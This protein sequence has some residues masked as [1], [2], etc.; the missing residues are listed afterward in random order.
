MHDALESEPSMRTQGA[1]LPLYTDKVSWSFTWPQCLTS[2]KA[3][4]AQVE[5]TMVRGSTAPGSRLELKP[6]MS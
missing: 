4:K 1:K 6:S 3:S 5:L 2:R